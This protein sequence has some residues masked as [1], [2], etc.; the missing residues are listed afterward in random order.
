G[1]LWA[2]AVERAMSTADT[3]LLLVPSRSAS[4]SFQ[5]MEIG[6]AVDRARRDENFRVVPVLVPGSDPAS[7]PPALQL[8]NRLDL[9]DAS[10]R[11]KQ[12]VRLAA[13]IARDPNS[14]SPA[15]DEEVGD[16][17]RDSGDA[18]GALPYYVRATALSIARLGEE[19]RRIAALHR[20][21]GAT[22]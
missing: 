11:S 4:S 9:H 12:L 20:K 15:D 13:V 22:K 10:Q 21:I 5:Q 17:L 3:L 8:Y 1:E 6:L 7:L 14:G 2:S 19:D 18:A 16:R